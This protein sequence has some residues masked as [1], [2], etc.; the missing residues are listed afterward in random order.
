[1]SALS[2]WLRSLKPGHRPAPARKNRVR[3]TLEALET[4]EVPTVSFTP[5]FS[6][7]AVTL[8]AGTTLAQE[9]APSLQSPELVIIFAGSD[10]MTNQ[11]FTNE[12][13]VLASIQSILNSPYLS[14]LTQY[15]S[16]GKASLFSNWTTTS[17]PP[18]TGPGG[19]APSDSDLHTFVTNQIA[20]MRQGPFAR[21][22]PVPNAKAIYMVISDVKDSTTSQGTHGYNGYRS[23]SPAHYAYAGTKGFSGFALDEFTMTFSHELAESMAPGIQVNDP[24]NLGKDSQICDGEPETFGNGYGY[25]LNG[26]L[27]Q[28]YWSQSDNAFIVP[29]GNNQVVTLSWPTSTFNG[30]FNLTAKGNP[31]VND[32]FTLDRDP[33]TFRQ[34]LT[35]NN[36]VFSFD[37][38]QLNAISLYTQGGTNTVNI[39]SVLFGESVTVDSLS[40]TSNDTVVVGNNGSLSDIAGPV[41]VAN[42]CGGKTALVI[43]SWADSPTNI[44]ITNNSVSLAGL[45]TIDYTPYGGPSGWSGVRSVT[46]DDA[47]GTNYI[48]AQSVSAYAPVT[49]VG[50]P[51]DVLYGPAANQV[52]LERLQYIGHTWGVNL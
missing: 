50:N 23:N 1:M 15:G 9:E 45:A 14:A 52:N 6:G 33:V 8:P 31:N 4:R 22:V 47:Y 24:G 35:L 27:V 13:T 38:G 42:S 29:D 32:V 2:N 20:S 28:A 34:R 10:W 36:Q 41:N 3:L 39:K 43:Q 11:G 51:F 7:T 26:A 37:G 16:D 49:V 21:A 48:D 44:T 17:V 46:I 19:L 40:S 18:L 30:T 12:Q 5:H 25:R